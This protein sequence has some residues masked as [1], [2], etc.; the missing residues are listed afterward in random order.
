MSGISPDTTD[1]FSSTPLDQSQDSEQIVREHIGWMLSLAKR[2]LGGDQDA[3]E[4]AVQDAFVSAFRAMDLLK[5][6]GSIKPWL[7]RITINAALTKL[8]QKKRQAE[9]PI[10]EFLPEFDQNDCRLEDR[11]SYLARLEDVQY[12]QERLDM[13]SCAFS[14]IPESYRIVLQLRDIEGYDTLEVADL[15]EISESNVKVRLHR[16]RSALK[17]LIEPMLRGEIN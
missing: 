8:R 13:L 9:Q 7:H 11:W 5:E 16:A 12:N 4:D 3:A 2:T 10:N 6:P 17:K 14:S 1:D 15:L